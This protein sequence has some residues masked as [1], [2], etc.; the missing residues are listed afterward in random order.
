MGR[1]LAKPLTP[2]LQRLL[3]A[4]KAADLKE[5]SEKMGLSYGTVRNWHTRER[6]RGDYLIKAQNETGKPVSWFSESDPTEAYSLADGD[7]H[8]HPAEAGVA[9]SS[10]AEPGATYLTGKSA[11][12]GGGGPLIS[13]AA[14]RSL[15]SV[16]VLEPLRLTASGPAVDPKQFEVIP[17]YQGE[18]GADGGP[19]PRL[20]EVA[21]SLSFID[22]RFGG[23]GDKLRMLVHRGDGMN[24]TILHGDEIFIDTRVR[25]VRAD[26]IYALRYDGGEE[27]VKRVQRKL[28]GTLIVSS[29]NERYKPEELP[30]A[31]AG[32]LQIV[33]MMVWP[34]VR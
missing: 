11:P 5:L 32:R 1:A 10:V 18:T 33:G 4:Y 20:G 13:P 25:D 17:M 7:M 8:S 12:K 14:Q 27:V 3:L 34:R 21:F 24:P 16:G 31:D 22:R 28:N 29:D 23:P 2:T 19:D 6:V 15:S 9:A 26:G 30:P